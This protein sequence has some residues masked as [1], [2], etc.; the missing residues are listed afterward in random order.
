MLHHNITNFLQ[1]C[2]RLNFSERSIDTL[3]FQL[4]EINQF[5]NL[6]GI[7]TK[8]DLRSLHHTHFSQKP[9]AKSQFHIDF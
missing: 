6:S 7:S 3:N 8:R 1:Y 4:N 9:A 5:L 2:K